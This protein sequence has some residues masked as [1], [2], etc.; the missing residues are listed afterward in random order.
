MRCSRAVVKVLVVAEPKC[1][2]DAA[3][4][5]AGTTS[6]APNTSCEPHSFPYSLL[7]LLTE[8]SMATTRTRVS[9]QDSTVASYSGPACRQLVLTHCFRQIFES[10]CSRRYNNMASPACDQ[11]INSPILPTHIIT[12]SIPPSRGPRSCMLIQ[13]SKMGQ[14]LS[15]TEGKESANCPHQSEPRR[16]GLPR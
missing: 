6:H 15:R 8:D 10:S 5:G 13:M 4:S 2:Q 9:N 11:N 16:I 1:I 7:G 14:K 12:T 3:N